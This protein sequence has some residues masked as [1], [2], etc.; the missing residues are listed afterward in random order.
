MKKYHLVSLKLDESPDCDVASSRQ[1]RAIWKLMAHAQSRGRAKSRDYVCEGTPEQVRDNPP[2]ALYVAALTAG[3]WRRLSD[4]CKRAPE[5]SDLTD[6]EIDMPAEYTVTL[7]SSYG[8]D[9]RGLPITIQE[10]NP[11]IYYCGKA[12]ELPIFNQ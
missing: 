6:I 2:C 11:A 3:E 4:L 9:S 1:A 7:D 10:W 12:N 8:L 5:N